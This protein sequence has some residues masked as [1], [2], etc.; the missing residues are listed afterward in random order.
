MGL[1]EWRDIPGYEG[2]YQACDDGRIKSLFRYKR[3]L[4]PNIMPNGY[5]TVE[6]FKN[7][8]SQR[9][10]IHRLI[11]ITFLENPDAKSQVNHKDEN[12]L[13]NT[14]SN[15]EWVSPRENMN[16]GTRTERQRLH[17]DYS[18]DI[19]KEIARRNG[20]SVSKPVMQYAKDGS[21][22]KEYESA[23][24]ACRQTGINSS[25]ISECCQGK[26]YKTVGGY[27][28]KFKKEE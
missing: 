23:K 20:K 18:A 5:A 3:E 17:T 11:A 22:I 15:L 25:H 16:Y 10:L 28:W 8:S 21:F 27:V 12:K 26:R 1:P 7:K 4:K 14:V 9:F 2:L 6:L 13:N 24:E 19:R